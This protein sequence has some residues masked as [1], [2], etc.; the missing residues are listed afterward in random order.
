[1]LTNYLR[2]F[3]TFFQDHERQMKEI[4][5]LEKTSDWQLLVGALLLRH[6]GQLVS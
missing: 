4:K 1:M 3:T 6:M 5:L 2:D